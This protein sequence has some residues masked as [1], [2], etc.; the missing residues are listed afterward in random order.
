M[1]K[2]ATP[3]KT[4]N[5]LYSLIISQMLLLHTRKGELTACKRCPTQEFV[6]LIHNTQISVKISYLLYIFFGLSGVRI[7]ETSMTN[8]DTNTLSNYRMKYT[9]PHLRHSKRTE[10]S[11]KRLSLKLL[12]SSKNIVL[13]L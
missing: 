2:T 4:N 11:S 7:T 13:S 3:H 6:T 10:T 8:V 9:A 1:H 12:E 5:T